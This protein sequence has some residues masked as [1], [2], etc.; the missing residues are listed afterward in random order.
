MLQGLL[1]LYLLRTSSRGLF[2]QLIR[3]AMLSVST[4]YLLT[5]HV[6][7]PSI[8]KYPSISE[9]KIDCDE[10]FTMRK[11]SQAVLYVTTLGSQTEAGFNIPG[12]WC[13]KPK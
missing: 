9:Y 2:D 3:N 5:T 8:F 1:D 13:F 4:S 6:C 11:Q 7:M 10:N 12:A